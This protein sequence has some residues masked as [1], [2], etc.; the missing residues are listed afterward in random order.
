MT[1]P[2]QDAFRTSDEHELLR[3]SVRE[4]VTD[5]VAP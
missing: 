2:L 3:A 4:L 1:A 5:K